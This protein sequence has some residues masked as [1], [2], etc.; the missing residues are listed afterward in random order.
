M[1][2]PVLIRSTVQVSHATVV[3]VAKSLFAALYFRP[4]S[5]SGVERLVGM[6]I[7]F[8]VTGLAHRTVG[9]VARTNVLEV[10]FRVTY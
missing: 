2:A 6:T 4:S 8:C 9:G 7:C 1:C 10:V 5:L 3:V